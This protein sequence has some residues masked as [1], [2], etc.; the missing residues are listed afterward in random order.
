MYAQEEMYNTNQYMQPQGGGGLNQGGLGGMG[1]GGMGGQGMNQGMSQGGMGG[2]GG[3]GGMNTL[4]PMQPQM[5]PQ[6]QMQP[7]SQMQPQGQVLGGMQPGG[8]QGGMQQG[9][10]G[11]F[12]VAAPAAQTSTASMGGLTPA[13]QAMYQ[14]SGGSVCLHRSSMIANWGLEIARTQ[15]THTAH[16]RSNFRAQR[17]HTHMHIHSHTHTIHTDHAQTHTLLQR[18]NLRT[19]HARTPPP[20]HTHKTTHTHTHTHRLHA[21]S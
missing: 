15:V 1:P 20:T 4:S 11:G 14:V 3:G 9:G 5:Q 16:T 18:T 13:M 2:M 6:G 8:M 12:A 7:Q 21:R 17:T 19:D 10:F